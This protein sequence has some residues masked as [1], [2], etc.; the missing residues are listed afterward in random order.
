MPSLPKF[1]LIHLFRAVPIGE[2]VDCIFI[3]LSFSSILLT[4]AFF[5]LYLTLAHR[6]SVKL[7]MSSDNVNFQ[8]F[9][10]YIYLLYVFRNV[11]CI[12]SMLILLHC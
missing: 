6:C 4:N 11:L 8:S 7:V 1:G 10:K 2:E 12:Q 3:I 9:M 5:A